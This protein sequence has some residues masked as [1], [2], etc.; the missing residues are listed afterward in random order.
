MHMIKLS[1]NLPFYTWRAVLA[2]LGNRGK[3][4]KI[5]P[6]CGREFGNSSIRCPICKVDLELMREARR[7]TVNAGTGRTSAYHKESAR[8]EVIQKQSVAPGKK[9]PEIP[10]GPSALSIIALIFSLIGCLGFIGAIL[11]IVDLCIKDGKKRYVL[12]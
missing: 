7:T 6:K 9:E 8:T 1:R 2:L 4:M 5:C 12:F 3:M 11:A 10:S